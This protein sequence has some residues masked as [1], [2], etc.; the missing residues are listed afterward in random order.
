MTCRYS[1]LQLSLQVACGAL[2]LFVAFLCQAQEQANPLALVGGKVYTSPEARPLNNAVVLLEH[3]KIARVGKRSAVTIP[4]SA[5]V[6]DCKGK[7]ITAGFWNS[8]VHFTEPQWQD[9]ATAD[10]HKLEQRMQEML[11]SWGFTTAFDIGS[12][13]KNTLALRRRVES[14][15]IAGPKIYT[16]AGNIFPENGI[17]VYIPKE[18]ASQLKP[19]EAA[20]PADAARLA[21][22]SLD[23]GGDGIKLFTGAIMGHGQVTPMPTGVIRAAVDVAHRAGKPVFAHASNHIGTDNALAGG[24]DILAHTIPI[25]Q[26]F[27]TDELARMKAQHVALIPTLTLWEVELSKSHASPEDMRAFVQKGIGELGT[28]FKQGGPILFGTDVG[29]TQHYD[30]TQEYLLMAE[31]GMGWRDILAS[32]TSTPAMFFKAAH[33]GELAEGNQADLVILGGDPAK[34]I[35]NFARVDFTIRAGKV[36]YRK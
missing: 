24:V 12:F 9:A 22:Q 23:L 31:S 15:E 30:T 21:R 20:T 27:T 6:I 26:N 11:T 3:G 36:I 17:P 28:Y 32:L 5:Q 19:L 34:D 10:A 25:E 7:V 18:L 8:H 35:R 4:K 16:T 13:P 33:T 1:R 2:I 29:Y 14:G